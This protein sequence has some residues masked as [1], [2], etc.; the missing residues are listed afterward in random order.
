MKLDRRFEPKRSFIIIAVEFL[1]K[2][3]AIRNQSD[4]YRVLVELIGAATVVLSLVFVGYQIQ[5]ST[6]VASAQAVFELNNSVNR[7]IR[8]IA[9]DPAAAELFISATN[10][11]ESLSIN[12]RFRYDLWTRTFLNSNE[13]AWLFHQKGVIDDEDYAGWQAGI[14]ETLQRPGVSE[15]M[16]SRLA[17]YAKGFVED[18]NDPCSD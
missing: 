16:A 18:V 6:A 7:G 2:W 9:L 8:E 10:D 11:L 1:E 4:G 17:T 15:F 12:E 5:R 14:C 13:S 3:L